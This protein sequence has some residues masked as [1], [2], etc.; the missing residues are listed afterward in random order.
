MYNPP[1]EGAVDGDEFEYVELK[2]LGTTTLD[3]TGLSFSAGINFSFTNGTKLPPGG[4][5][6]LGRNAAQL[7]ARYPGL[8]VN[9]I[10]TGRL[11]NGGERVAISHPVAGVIV[12]V[13]Y[14]DRAPWPVAADGF[15]FSLVLADTVARTYRVSDSPLGSPG[16]DGPA[17]A[18]G[19][20]VLN[21]VL[22]SSTEP[23]RD[24]I[25]LMNTTGLGINIGGWYLTDDPAYPWKFRIPDGTTIAAGGYLTFDEG[26]FNPTPGIGASFSLS[27]LGDD[28]YS[29]LIIVPWNVERLQPWI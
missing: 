2:N 7:A 6:L 11:D 14:E 3:L 12:E 18:I 5:F 9:G 15:G 1:A 28:V 20:V 8:V 19:G 4:L 17:S 23:L 25:E 21:E 24:T 10:Y 27:S 16:S 26:Q 13:T 22:S 29:V